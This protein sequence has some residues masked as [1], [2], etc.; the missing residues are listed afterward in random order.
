MIKVCPNPH[1]DA[2]YHK[3][4]K[5]DKACKDCGFTIKRINQ[6]TYDK[7]FADRF[8]QYDYQT[9]DYYRGA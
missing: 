7:K 4:K 2:V 1:C 3:C 6:V 8:F 9:M 5:S